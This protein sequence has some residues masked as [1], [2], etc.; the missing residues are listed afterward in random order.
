M[1]LHESWSGSEKEVEVA[2]GG[3]A[4]GSSHCDVIVDSI[5][6][7]ASMPTGL[8]NREISWRMWMRR[9]FGVV[10]AVSQFLV[11]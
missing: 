10:K 11:L 3:Q 8:G 9:Q 2:E 6:C 4:E 1:V 5:G 7:F